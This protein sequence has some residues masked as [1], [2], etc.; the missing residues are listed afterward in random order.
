MLTR[1]GK[2]KDIATQR[3]LI[4]TMFSS[5]ATILVLL[6]KDVWLNDVS[7]LS[8]RR[9]GLKV[10]IVYSVT[11]SGRNNTQQRVCYMPEP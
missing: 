10:Y 6:D 2:K 5:N 7:H 3:H 1:W 4:C 11:Q 9:S 8:I